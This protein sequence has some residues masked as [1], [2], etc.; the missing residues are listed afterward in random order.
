M[1]AKLKAQHTCA[2]LSVASPP[3]PHAASCASCAR[4]GLPEGAHTSTRWVWHA[5]LVVYAAQL[6]RNETSGEQSASRF[7]LATVHAVTTCSEASHAPLRCSTAMPTMAR[8]LLIHAA[9]ALVLLVLLPGTMSR[10][11][12][13]PVQISQGDRETNCTF[14]GAGFDPSAVAHSD[15]DGEYDY[16]DGEDAAAAA[17][18]VE[19]SEFAPHCRLAEFGT[20]APVSGLQV[21]T[22]DGD[23]YGCTLP[24]GAATGK[25][26]M[27]RRGKCPFTDKASAAA[28]AGAAM[29]IVV[30]TDEELPT[31]GGRPDND[32]P[33]PVVLVQAHTGASLVRAMGNGDVSAAVTVAS[34][35]VPPTL[36]AHERSLLLQPRRCSGH[37]RL[38]V[39][40]VE[41]EDTV[42]AGSAALWNSGLIR[43][44]A[45]TV[46]PG[47]AGAD[48][49]S[50]AATARA[51]IRNTT[52]DSDVVVVL[53][54]PSGSHLAHAL[55]STAD[56]VAA[57]FCALHGAAVFAGS[58][59]CP[60]CSPDLAAKYQSARTVSAFAQR[61]YPLPTAFVAYADAADSL[62]GDLEQGEGRLMEVVH[63]HLD[64]TRVDSVGHLLYDLQGKALATALGVDGSA[65][66][67][68]GLAE[69]ATEADG[70]VQMDDGVQSDGGGAARRTELFIEAPGRVATSIA[71]TS[72]A[73]LVNA[74]ASGRDRWLSTVVRGGPLSQKSVA[75]DLGNPAILA[76]PVR[77]E[78]GD[79]ESAADLGDVQQPRFIPVGQ[80][81]SAVWCERCFAQY[82]DFERE[83]EATGAVDDDGE[84]V[85]DTPGAEVERP[86]TTYP[87]ATV[88][89]LREWATWIV[90]DSDEAHTPAQVQGGVAAGDT[91]F[92]ANDHIIQFFRDYST[93]MGNPYVLITDSA[94]GYREEDGA[95]AVPGVW[96]KVVLADKKL[97]AWWAMDP[98]GKKLSKV[99]YT[100]GWGGGRGRDGA[101]RAVLL[102]RVS[103]SGPAA[104]LTA[105]A[106]CLVPRQIHALPLGVSARAEDG[107]IELL[108]A[109]RATAPPMADPS[110]TTL[111]CT[112]GDFDGDLVARVKAAG[113]SVQR[114]A[115]AGEAERWAQLASCTFTAGSAGGRDSAAVWDAVA[116]GSVPIVKRNRLLKRLYD[117]APH[118][119]VLAVL[120]VTPVGTPASLTWGGAVSACVARVVWVSC[121]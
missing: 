57:R 40:A 94:R 61:P 55:T 3:R 71:G 8:A 51:T 2:P 79:D 120:A 117:A 108:H 22:L 19:Q 54:G 21:V 119:L 74:L 63:Q 31:L 87:F 83:A 53:L 102:E 90:D 84:P 75:S 116:M 24:A 34:P 92:V 99:R 45:V 105:V 39:V 101:W 95:Q 67:G 48:V 76:A 15:D 82:A 49:P 59:T 121:A 69:A 64:V 77:V 52:I 104:L 70:G 43:R 118:A 114:L 38:V 66:G 44:V 58:D 14:L 65:S 88:Q 81:G 115:R 1:D 4:P 56:N 89:A 12:A 78:G 86:S 41:P 113:G 25:A 72:P 13:T 96:R 32:I 97:L 60:A 26:L 42:T 93:G 73:I 16:E 28:R 6:L 107:S 10:V 62:L 80:A 91:V 112:D 27:V 110:R 36:R 9:A 68:R 103:Q 98:S 111:L 7:A 46:V 109:A 37:E 85:A 47:G 33:F 50:M 106:S 23:V 17:G 30:N 18:R 5:P 100:G 35:V 11:S 20:A 29:L